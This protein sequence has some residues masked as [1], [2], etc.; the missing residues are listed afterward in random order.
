MGLDH[1]FIERFRQRL[2]PGIL[3]QRRLRRTQEA[4]LAGARF[5]HA[6]RLELRVGLGDSVAIDT[7]FLSKRPYRRQLD[8]ASS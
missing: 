4:A 8:T 1:R 6:L 3:A 2:A 5:D 7:E